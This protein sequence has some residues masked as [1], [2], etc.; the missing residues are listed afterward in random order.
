MI[1]IALKA[2]KMALE[3]ALQSHPGDLPENRCFFIKITEIPDFDPSNP[4]E[5]WA[6]ER[7][8]RKTLPREGTETTMLAVTIPDL[9]KSKQRSRILS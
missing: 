4:H 7:R 3:M 6:P 2:I 1:L 5:Y 8:I 9:T